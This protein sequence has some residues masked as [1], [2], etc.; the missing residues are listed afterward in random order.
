MPVY[1]GE[2]Y[3]TEAVESILN[4]TYK[5]FE[6][7]IIDDGSTDDTPQILEKYAKLDLRVKLIKHSKN[8]GLVY[9][10][11]EGLRKAEGEFIARMDADD[12]SLPERF[13]RQI[14]IFEN[15]KKILICGSWAL[16]I[17]KKGNDLFKMKSPTGILLKYN[18]WKPSPLIHPSVMFRNFDNFDDYYSGD[19][20]YAE[21]YELW[22]RIKIKNNGDFYNISKYLLKYRINDIGISKTNR[23]Q[24]LLSSFKAFNAVLGT[25]ILLTEYLSLICQTFEITFRKRMKILFS[26]RKKLGY[27][28]W[29]M[30]LDNMYYE[31][32]KILYKINPKLN[33]YK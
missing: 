12:I 19:Y 23:K 8:K 20:L 32:R 9:S 33:H 25:N 21:D 27:P 2:R 15:N 4:Q 16:A 10:L 7:L 17:D 14:E 26:L 11:N 28:L 24:Q 30:L 31:F 13:E 1:N 22:L 5:N 6:F 29:F 18:F 3:L